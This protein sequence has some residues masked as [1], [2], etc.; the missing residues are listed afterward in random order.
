MHNVSLLFCIPF[1]EPF[2]AT[3]V[4]H[5]AETTTVVG[6][7]TSVL[8]CVAYGVPTPSLTWLSDGIPLNV[9]SARVMETVVVEREKRIPMFMS[10]LELCKT[11]NSNE[12]TYSCVAE[13]VNSSDMFTTEIMV[14]STQG[15]GKLLAVV[16]VAHFI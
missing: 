1:P 4:L 8:T 15:I 2:P 5:P 6:G 13:N 11:V 12:S 14:I 9:S 7:V 3:V 16:L 10:V